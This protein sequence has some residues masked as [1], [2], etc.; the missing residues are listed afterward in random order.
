MLKR[1]FRRVR[2][3]MM[4]DVLVELAELRAELARRDRQLE[5]MLL[6]IVLAKEEPQGSSNSSSL[7]A[8]TAMECAVE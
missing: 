8:Y 1:L 4:A 3:L 7:A 5:A 6:T 2:R